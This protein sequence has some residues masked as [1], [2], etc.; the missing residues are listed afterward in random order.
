MVQRSELPHAGAG[1]FAAGGVQMGQVICHLWGKLIS[2]DVW[3]ELLRRH[4]DLTHDES[5]GQE[6]YTAP[7]RAGS[8]RCIDIPAVE[9]SAALTLLLG[10]SCCPA[11]FINHPPAGRPAN[12]KL[13]VPN[14][15]VG[16][17]AAFFQSAEGHKYIQVVATAPIAAGEEI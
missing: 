4:K 14:A 3:E 12:A 7:V 13:M 9:D 2:S 11:S 5:S 16:P 15:A 8:L 17:A 6:D 1:L 10:S